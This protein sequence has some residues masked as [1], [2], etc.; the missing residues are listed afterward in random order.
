MSKKKKADDAPPATPFA[1]L[2]AIVQA[3]TAGEPIQ[4]DTIA[5]APLREK[6]AV[7]DA[8]GRVLV[9]PVVCEGL[10]YED[11]PHRRAYNLTINGRECHFVGDVGDAREYRPLGRR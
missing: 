2:A 8:F 6:E 3:E 4:T 11:V 10:R 7:T 5:V 1:N 9:G